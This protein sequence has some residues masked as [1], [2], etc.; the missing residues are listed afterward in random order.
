MRWWHNKPTLFQ[1]S[2]PALASGI[3]FVMFRVFKSI[4]PMEFHDGFQGEK[5]KTHSPRIHFLS[6]LFN[7]LN[8][9]CVHEILTCEEEEKRLGAVEKCIDLAYTLKKMNNLEGMAAVMSALNSAPISRLR[10]LFAKL[11]QKTSKRFKTMELTMTHNMYWDLF[12]TCKPPLIPWI[13]PKLRELRYLYDT[14]S[15]HKQW[16]LRLDMK[17][18]GNS[19]ND[20]LQHKNTPYELSTP[21]KS[22]ITIL[23]GMEDGVGYVGLNYDFHVFEDDMYAVSQ[24]FRPGKEDEHKPLPAS[25]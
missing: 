2:V 23:E 5:R 25:H 17:A 19:I 15:G 16:D 24:S 18:V 20:Y 3:T 22:L 9:L 10:S 7:R 8:S 4:E 12:K 6:L 11:K 14:Q 21:E 1:F 13:A